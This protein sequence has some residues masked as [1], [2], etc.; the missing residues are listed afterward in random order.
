MGPSHRRSTRRDE[1]LTNLGKWD[2]WYRGLKDEPQAYGDT[3]TYDLGALW[4]A[5]CPFV[6]DW[7]CGKGWFR[8][9]LKPEQR[10]YGLD[11]SKTPF[12]DE[13]VDLATYRGASSGIFM[14]HVLEHDYRWM[15]I[16]DNAVASFTDRMFL[17]VFTPMS[18]LTHEITF[19]NDPGVPDLSFSME[20]L[21]KRWLDKA[22]WTFQA[23]ETNTQYGVE[24][25]FFLEKP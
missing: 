14:R 2:G 19:A 9:C 24:T 8:Q 23:L 20:D 15:N 17:A 21:F 25:A 12:A 5:D 13:I 1:I 10:Y 7:G 6:A 4:L 22:E 3:T 11:G 16:L 18:D